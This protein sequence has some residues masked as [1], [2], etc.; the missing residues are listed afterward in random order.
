[1]YDTLRPDLLTA[2]P[3][4]RLEM[5]MNQKTVV[6]SYFF[7][8]NQLPYLELRRPFILGTQEEKWKATLAHWFM[9][10]LAEEGLLTRYF[11]Q[12][13]DGLEFQTGLAREKV[14]SIHGG[15]A[16]VACENCGKEMPA[17]EFCDEVRAKIKDIHGE[18]PSAP[19]ESEHVLCPTCGAAM[20]KPSTILFGDPV[21]KGFETYSEAEAPE[22][23]LIIVAG[24][25]LVVKP[26]NTLV[27]MVSSS[28]PRLIVNREQVGTGEIQYGPDATRDVFAEGFCDEGF[29]KLI[30]ALGWEDKVR[31][32]Q[33]LLP[34]ASRRVVESA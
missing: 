27:D 21:A 9:A 20:V 7:K 28:C 3:A 4:Q 26:A 13:I 18:D 32:I 15:L 2:T 16:V 19:Q 34:E 1:M 33:H 17:E 12:N 22:A 25:S 30:L 5:G 11:T 31:R 6:S 23:D 24:T 29:M 14:V 10:F 8:E